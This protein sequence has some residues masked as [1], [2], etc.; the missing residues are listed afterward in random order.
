MLKK[1]QLYLVSEEMLSVRLK[2]FRDG[3][4]FAAEL[5]VS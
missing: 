2:T 1:Q 3:G 5:P 4:Q